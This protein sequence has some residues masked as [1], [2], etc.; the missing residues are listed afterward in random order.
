MAAYRSSKLGVAALVGHVPRLALGGRN[1]YGL[2][3]AAAEVSVVCGHPIFFVRP[4]EQ[5]ASHLAERFGRMMHACKLN[6]GLV[7]LMFLNR[8]PSGPTGPYLIPVALRYT[9]LHHTQPAIR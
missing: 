5:A 8:K 4:H 3:A 9:A 7:L 6:A 1:R 2:A